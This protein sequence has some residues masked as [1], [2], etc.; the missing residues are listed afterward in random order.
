MNFNGRGAYSFASKQ[1]KLFY[2]EFEFIDLEKRVRIEDHS[3]VHQSMSPNSFWSL[4]MRDL[5]ADGRNPAAYDVAEQTIN[6]YM[7]STVHLGFAPMKG[8]V[9]PKSWDGYDIENEAFFDVKSHNA[10]S[11]L[12]RKSF[13][14]LR[15]DPVEIHNFFASSK[16]VSVYNYKNRD[17]YGITVTDKQFQ[18]GEVTRS[19]IFVFV[20]WYDEQSLERS[21]V[22]LCLRYRGGMEVES[23]RNSIAS[24][25]NSSIA[26]N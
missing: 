26:G 1:N 10:A 4:M 6:K 19:S 20:Y 13:E 9:L 25:R 15:N 16:W 3:G 7:S 24:Q 8:L 21:P 14:R 2:P 5:R 23:A 22:I 11:K 18:Y 17:L 12:T